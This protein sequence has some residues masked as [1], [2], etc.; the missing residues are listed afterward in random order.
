MENGVAN[1][2]KRNFQCGNG[3]TYFRGAFEKIVVSNGNAEQHLCAVHNVYRTWYAWT[4]RLDFNQSQN[5]H[6]PEYD[7]KNECIKYRN[8]GWF[9]ELHESCWVSITC[10]FKQM[11]VIW[12]IHNFAPCGCEFETIVAYKNDS[13]QTKVFTNLKSL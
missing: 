4:T 7:D 8:R 2:E 1:R 11:W 13:I 5:Y 12:V 9:S 6:I 3:S 10:G